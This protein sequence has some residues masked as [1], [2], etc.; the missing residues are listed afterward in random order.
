MESGE[1]LTPEGYSLATSSVD[2]GFH[3]TV[4]RKLIFQQCHLYVLPILWVIIEYN[5]LQLLQCS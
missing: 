3:F 1:N 5:G 4:R 2:C